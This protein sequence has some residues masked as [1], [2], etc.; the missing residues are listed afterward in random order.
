MTGPVGIQRKKAIAAES[1]T[2]DSL[3][4]LKESILT[5]VKE[6]DMIL[7]MTFTVEHA[8]PRDIS[9]SSF[10]V[11]ENYPKITRYVW[12]GVFLDKE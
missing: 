8:D 1:R 7:Y 3:E 2:Y 4:E 9:L 11:T 6:K 10:T 5:E 12:R